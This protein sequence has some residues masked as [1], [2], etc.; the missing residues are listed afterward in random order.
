MSFLF[1]HANNRQQAVVMLI[2][3]QM[4]LYTFHGRF[5]QIPNRLHD[6]KLF[7]CK[8]L[9]WFSWHSVPLS[10]Y[11]YVD[12]GTLT[13]LYVDVNNFF[14]ARIK[15]LPVPFACTTTCSTCKMIV[16]R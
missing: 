16:F 11:K 9:R 2:V 8:S 1:Q 14:L 15:I 13:Y 7:I 5:T 10:T 12:R 3:R 6:F 4:L